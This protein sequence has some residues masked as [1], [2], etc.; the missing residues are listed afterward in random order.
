MS[1]VT[2]TPLTAPQLAALRTDNQHS[3]LYLAIYTPQ[4]VYTAMVNQTFTSYDMIS[5]I[6]IDTGAGTLADVLPGMTCLVGSTPGA[7]DIGRVRV[8]ETPTTTTLKIGE[9]SD[10][11]WANNQ[12]LTIVDDLNIW[13]RHVRMNGS[14]P[15]MDVDIT[16]TDQHSKFA[17]VP[18]MGANAV[19]WLN[20]ASATVT[21]DGST[22]YAPGSTIA[23]WSWTVSAGASITGGTTATPTVTV[24][25]AGTYRVACTVTSAAGASSTGYRYIFA[26][27]DSH[28]AE[29][30]FALQSC[31]ADADSGGWSFGISTPDTALAAKINAGT[32]VIL[33]ERA[34]SGSVGPIAGRENIVAMGWVV[35]ETITTDPES[36]ST[37]F[38]VDNL[39][40]WLKRIPAFP[41]GLD[42][43]TTAAAWT[44]MPGLTV[45][46]YLWHLLTWRTTATKITDCILTGDTRYAGRLSASGTSLWEQMTTI[47]GETILARVAV[48][49]LNQLCAYIP[50]KYGGTAVNLMTITD[51]DRAKTLTTPR[52]II[53]QSAQIT[54][55]GI[56]VNAEGTAQTYFSLS[57]G[58]VMKRTG[59][60]SARDRLLLT[61]QTQ[62][63]TLA[64]ILAGEMNNP[65]PEISI[66]WN[67]P[68]RSFDIAPAVTAALNGAVIA[69]E[70]VDIS[71]DP[72]TGRLSVTTKFSGQPTAEIGMNGDIPGLPATPGFPPP[73]PPPPLPPPALPP[74]GTIPA[75]G[76]V[77]MAK[78][79]LFYCA[80]INATTPHWADYGGG[81]VWALGGGTIATHM[82]V[83]RYGTRVYMFSVPSP[84]VWGRVYLA[85]PSLGRPASEWIGPA[86]IRA[87]EALGSDTTASF[88]VEQ[89]AVDPITGSALIV[90]GPLNSS[91]LL[92]PTWYW[93]SASGMPQ[94]QNFISAYTLS[95]EQVNP[96]YIFGRGYAGMH[97]RLVTLFP[98]STSDNGLT[99]TR[100]IGGPPIDHAVLVGETGRIM[101]HNQESSD[102]GLTWSA[103]SPGPGFIIGFPNSQCTFA[104]S[105]D[106]SVYLSGNAAR[107]AVIRSTDGGNNWTTVSSLGGVDF[108]I[109][110][111]SVAPGIWLRCGDF[112]VWV[113]FDDG[114]TWI[115]K[116]GNLQDDFGIG[117]DKHL[118]S[119]G[120]DYFA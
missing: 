61:S 42:I 18:V 19:V 22:A 6:T 10:V 68:N 55:S 15:L 95:Q 38:T 80:D 119:I 23:S 105:A 57:P 96:A 20:G 112:G 56:S 47:A 11:A 24:T 110:F 21:F 31:S 91:N 70:G 49:R 82:G 108:S 14:I 44:D 118:S 85:E 84:D 86:Y 35:G 46:R 59:T 7:S 5:Q 2:P 30:D 107:N 97:S 67:W 114:V 13:P 87:C 79:R 106:G 72:T 3:R 28:P 88:G 65:T 36:G 83:H 63:N 109:G 98:S 113:S 16:Y 34:A 58:H 12:Y 99:S 54:L 52:Q 37:S 78:D 94:R 60:Q 102:G 73:P 45:D 40:G 71:H 103:W 116:T 27:D 32:L 41:V 93:T 74:L 111:C 8:R 66:E 120:I 89:L 62:A 77:M 100:V 25:A 39:A 26:F 9:T 90:A 101:S 75:R 50:P 29:S 43:K 69:C 33:F 64:G 4:T 81:N 51:A 115:N 53:S 48:N 117:A 76:V 104:A 1:A 92:S 17:P